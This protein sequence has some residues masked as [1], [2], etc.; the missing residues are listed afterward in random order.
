MRILG[1]YSAALCRARALSRHTGSIFRVF[2]DTS[3]AWNVERY[4]HERG[5]PIPAGEYYGPAKN[6]SGDIVLRG[7][8]AQSGAVTVGGVK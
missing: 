2:Q 4:V 6:G 5:R 8:V 3:L 1:G 7:T